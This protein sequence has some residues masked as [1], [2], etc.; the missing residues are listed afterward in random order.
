[1]YAFETF[2]KYRLNYVILTVTCYCHT[3][4]LTP[5]LVRLI[6]FLVDWPVLLEFRIG[7]SSRQL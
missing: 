3:L 4:A 6:V 7:A 2:D 1:M 5:S